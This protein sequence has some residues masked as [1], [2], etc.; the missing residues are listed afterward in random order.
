MNNHTNDDVPL[1]EPVRARLN[2]A[3]VSPDLIERARR[4]T[5]PARHRARTEATL[6]AARATGPLPPGDEVIRAAVLIAADLNGVGGYAGAGSSTGDCKTTRMA[7]AS[8][9]GKGRWNATDGAAWRGA[10]EAALQYLDARWMVV[11]GE[12]RLAVG[13]HGACDSACDSAVSA[14]EWLP[15]GPWSEAVGLAL[16]LGP[17]AHWQTG[18]LQLLGIP[19]PEGAAEAVL[20]A[21]IAVLADCGPYPEPETPETPEPPPEAEAEASEWLA[22]V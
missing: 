12:L 3:G 16:I 15:E 7:W 14:F 11:E 5:A 9:L 19:C 8:R 22:G 6:A 17:K 1:W 20:T 21:G 13:A 2:E 18:E 4:A 10:A